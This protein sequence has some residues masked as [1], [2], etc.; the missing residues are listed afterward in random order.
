MILW[1]ALLTG[2]HPD[3]TDLTVALYD[4][5]GDLVTG[6]DALSKYSGL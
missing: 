3:D 5:N 2:G 1:S 4:V 6:D